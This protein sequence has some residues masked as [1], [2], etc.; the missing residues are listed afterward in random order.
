MSKNIS[1][2]NLF[3]MNTVVTSTQA[4]RVNLRVT[5]KIHVFGTWE[6]DLRLQFATNSEAV[7][8][9]KKNKNTHNHLNSYVYSF[10]F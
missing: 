9:K 7:G 5:E 2:E 6:T 4:N 1:H 10:K 3:A 8:R